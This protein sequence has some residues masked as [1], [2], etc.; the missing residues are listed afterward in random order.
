MLS[1]SYNS[2]IKTVSVRNKIGGFFKIKVPHVRLIFISPRL[3]QQ[4]DAISLKG[5]ALW[6]FHAAGNNKSS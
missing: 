4:P 2:K 1:G 5:I 3:F 6:R